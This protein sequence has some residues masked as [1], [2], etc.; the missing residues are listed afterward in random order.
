MIRP[1]HFFYDVRE[2]L[3]SPKFLLGLGVIGLFFVLFV[4][5]QFLYLLILLFI[6]AIVGRTLIGRRCPR[7]DSLL[8]ERGAEPKPGDAFVLVITW[9]C[10]RD[11]FT[12]IEETRSN[13]GLFGPK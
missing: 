7:C 11:G 5:S 4:N 9:V 12:E 3:G 1:D 6:A 8:K 10:P 13:T 2:T